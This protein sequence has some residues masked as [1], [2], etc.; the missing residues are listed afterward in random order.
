MELGAGLQLLRWRQ[1]AGCH[2]TC[3][4][5]SGS[6]LSI[7]SFS[8]RFLGSGSRLSP[9]LKCGPDETVGVVSLIDADLVILALYTVQPELCL[10]IVSMFH[11]FNSFRV[12]QSNEVPMKRLPHEAAD[13]H[14]LACNNSVTTIAITFHFRYLMEGSRLQHIQHNDIQLQMSQ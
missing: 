13:I 12:A 3:R 2:R 8:R 1:C 5:A 7:K 11:V 4:C 10:I 14:C 9:A 6:R